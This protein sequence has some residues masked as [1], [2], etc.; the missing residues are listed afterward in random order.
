MTAFYSTGQTAEKTGIKARRLHYLL[1]LVD[2][3]PAWIGNRFLWTSNDI[4][5][6]VELDKTTPTRE[7]HDR[8]A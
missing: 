2:W 7:R 4:D 6:I 8:Q 5:A 3:Q 1:S